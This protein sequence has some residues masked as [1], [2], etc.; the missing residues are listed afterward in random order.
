VIRKKGE[1]FAAVFGGDE[2]ATQRLK[3]LFDAA[4]LRAK[5]P[6]DI[7]TALWK[8][9]I[10]IS[11]FATLT[12]YYDKSIGYICEKHFYEAK[13]LLEEIAAVAFSLNIDIKEEVAKALEVASKLPY[14]ASTSMHLDFSNQKRD[15]LETLSA[16]IVEQA[17][18]RGVEVPLMRTMYEAL[19]KR[20]IA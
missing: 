15:E 14:D 12:S 6:D 19:L 10:F 3:A 5:T 9:Y 7:K 17:D 16:Y 4:D 1:V 18:V 13:E 2:L 20:H 11:A 8:K